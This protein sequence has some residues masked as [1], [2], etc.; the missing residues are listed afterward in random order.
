MLIPATRYLDCESMLAWLKDVLL[1]EEHAVYRSEDGK[2]SHVEMRVGDG[3]MMFGPP[4]D[5]PFD[6]CMAD[7]AEIGGRETTTIYAVIRDVAERY[8]HAVDR[9]ARIILPLQ[10]QFYGGSSFT[11]ADPEGHFWTFGDFDPRTGHA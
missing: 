7:P 10:D 9:G 11:V 5:G 8:A 3:F 1:L 6:A 4:N 2:I